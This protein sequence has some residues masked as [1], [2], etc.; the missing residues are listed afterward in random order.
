MSKEQYEK[1]KA[2]EKAKAQGKNLAVQGVTTF[3]SRV[4]DFRAA[5]EAKA[6]GEKKGF[7]F[8]DLTNKNK[9]NYVRA[10]GG[11]ESYRSS[12]EYQQM[13]KDK[14]AELKRAREAQAKLTGAAGGYRA[15]SQKAAAPA[16]KKANFFDN[17]FGNK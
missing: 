5:D 13:V 2:K 16:P 7:R 1:L 14:E 4:L 17:L 6:A 11:R 3:R 9:D 10:A 8:P 15:G 12:K